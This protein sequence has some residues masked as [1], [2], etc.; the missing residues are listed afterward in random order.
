MIG[1]LFSY[2]L[3]LLPRFVLQIVP[4]FGHDFVGESCTSHGWL[5]FP[6][7]VVVDLDKVV[8][9]E[10]L[11]AV[12][13]DSLAFDELCAFLLELIEGCGFINGLLHLLNEGI[14]AVIIRRDRTQTWSLFTRHVT[15]AIA[16]LVC[17]A[18]PCVLRLCAGLEEARSL[19][20]VRLILKQDSPRI[21]AWRFVIFIWFS[22]LPFDSAGRS[23][24]KWLLEV[25]L[26]DL[27]FLD[28]REASNS[29][30][31]LPCVILVLLSILSALNLGVYLIKIVLKRCKR[32]FEGSLYL[33]LRSC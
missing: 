30:I 21:R 8:P 26:V 19:Q 25:L 6:H 15:Q 12:S 16:H 23:T 17:A 13:L 18:H 31:Q 7:F 28:G 11:A 10:L 2:D 5:V 20:E 33:L 22:H 4:L 29:S 32:I 24:A 9:L 1:S 14:R 3:L 27:L